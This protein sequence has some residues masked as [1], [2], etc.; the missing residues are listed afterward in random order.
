MSTARYG[1]GAKRFC[2]NRLIRQPCGAVSPQ[3]VSARLSPY[4]IDELYK[5]SRMR[6]SSRPV[7]TLVIMQALLPNTAGFSGQ[8]TFA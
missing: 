8:A 7:K 1:A 5:E 3:A 2:A 6:K 4:R